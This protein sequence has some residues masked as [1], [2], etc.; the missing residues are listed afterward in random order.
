MTN[1]KLAQVFHFDLYG[2]RDDKYDF[3]NENNLASIEWNEL[4]PNEPNYFLVNK[5]FDAQ[6]DY[7]KGFRVNELF[8]INSAGIVTAR[9][10]FTIHFSKEVVKKR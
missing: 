7:D 5:D 6:N 1:N 4:Q 9:D 10:E 8:T 2:K 3:L